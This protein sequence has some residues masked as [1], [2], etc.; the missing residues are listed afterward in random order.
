MRLLEGSGQ[1]LAAALPKSPLINLLSRYGK[2]M[3]SSGMQII[4][5][6]KAGSHGIPS[7]LDV[8]P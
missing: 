4:V 8:S 2:K 6:S 5:C 7:Y 1:H 3:L